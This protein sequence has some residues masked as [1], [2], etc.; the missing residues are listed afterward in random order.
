MA[1][2]L[3]LPAPAPAR[4]PMRL[5]YWALIA[6]LVVYCARPE[7]W[8]PGVGHLHLDKIAGGVALAAAAMSALSGQGRDLKLPKSVRLLV[9]LFV[10]LFLAAL[11]S[12]V[13]RGGALSMVMDDF[14]KVVLIAIVIV[15]TGTLAARLRTLLFVQAAT[16]VVIGAVSIYKDRMLSGWRLEGVLGGMYSNPNDLALS[17]A[18][19]VPLCFGFLLIAPG[20][21][22]KLAWLGSIVLILYTITLTM[23]RGGLLS[24][25]AA[26]GF[27]VW[28]FGFRGKR[29]W[30]VSLTLLL[31]AASIAIAMP[32][33]YGKRVYSILHP[34]ADGTGSANARIALQERSLLVTLEHPLLGVGPGDFQVLSGSWHV[35]HDSYT[36]MSAEGGVPALVLYLMIMWYAFADLRVAKRDRNPQVRIMAGAIQGALFAY[37]IGSFFSSVAY[38]FFPY[39]FV[40]YGCALR[41]AGA[42]SAASENAEVPA[43]APGELACAG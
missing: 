42:L 38:L 20:K 14:S 19:A 11:F 26:I 27:S 29:R 31:V 16:V 7:D 28:E 37:L 35:T 4:E 39:I 21:L 24:V 8:I 41:R 34:G 30:L 33:G 3:P 2:P 18:I 36:Q 12:P 43:A 32:S 17:L 13:W 25:L 6:F 22:R 15:W 9:V 23:S 10:Q 40:A 5:A 1:A